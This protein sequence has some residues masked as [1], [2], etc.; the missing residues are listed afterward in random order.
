MKAL[1]IFLIGFALAASIILTNPIIF[2]GDTLLRLMNRDRLMMG[3]QLPML[4]V[5]IAIVTKISA[6]AVWVRY[7][8]AVIGGIAGVAFFWMIR[9]LFGQ[10]WAFPAAL[11]F[12]SNPF[13]LAL[14]TV[15]FQE[16][17]MLAGVL[18]AFHFFYTERW[19]AAS[20]ALAVAC[21][22]RY[23][24][25]AACPVLA[26]AYLAKR[27][28]NGR[29][30]EGSASAFPSR[31]RQGAVFKAA[32]L[33]GWMPVVWILAKH[34]LSS[35]GHFV[36]ESSLTF[37]RL[38]RYVYLGWI[39]VKNTQVTV[40]LLALAGVWRLY[41]D[42]TLLNWRLA[43]QI[44]F[45]A[46]FLISIPF[47]AHGVM[48]DPERYVTAR[49]AV[50][51]IYFV[52][53]MSVL[54]LMKWPRWTWA[55]VALSVV[56]GAA[57]GHLYVWRETSKPDVQLSYQ[58]ARYLDGKVR[59]GERALILSQPITV[60]MLQGYLKKAQETGGEEG[61]RQARLELQQADLRGTDYSRVV[62]HS[63]LGRDRLLAPPATC[64]EWVAV[65]SDYP[66]A[67]RELAG[68]QPVDVLRSGPLSV[69]IL[70][71]KCEE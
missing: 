9:D 68:V 8:D 46:L 52:I 36:I 49:E 60:D 67:A 43:I 17:L 61:L 33:F 40:L 71:R 28:A 38:Q 39:T 24:A 42:R 54:G 4:Q 10:Q 11:L 58:L 23:E 50:I 19:I 32:V 53:L 62:V 41:K 29:G 59:T 21:L 2:G 45:V 16:M 31:D 13:F 25:W 37:G 55:I 7:M 56:L 26:V 18:L 12:V 34:G 20:L 1:A 51:P 15:P 14:S 66:D 44:A 30:A 63:R 64:G 3:H 48:P 70:R 35:P 47:S 22:T 65:W 69:T 57:G 27:P 6:S 5:L